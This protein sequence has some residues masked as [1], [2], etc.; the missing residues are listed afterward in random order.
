MMLSVIVIAEGTWLVPCLVSEGEWRRVCSRAT[1]SHAL[2][3]AAR[4][5][6][7]ALSPH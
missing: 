4:P 3:H 1:P 6:A 5:L 2:A 7:K